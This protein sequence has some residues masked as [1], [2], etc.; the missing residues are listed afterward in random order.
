MDPAALPPRTRSEEDAWVAGWA[1][2]GDTEALVEAVAHAI[3]ARRPQLA[4]RLVGLVPPD[5]QSGWCELEDAWALLRRA[6]MRRT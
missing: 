4:A 2:A 1:A 5:G 6:R 3:E